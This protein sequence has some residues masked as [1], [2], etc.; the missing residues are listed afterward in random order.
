MAKM[1][2]YPIEK[3][4]DPTEER[5]YHLL[6][7]ELNEE[8]T[9]L[10]S[11]TWSQVSNGNNPDP[12][13]DF[14]IMKPGS[15]IIVL[16]V[17]GGRWERKR[18][19]WHC[20][21]EP[22]AIEDDPFAQAKSNR[23]A[24]TDLL[25]K[26]GKWS[27]QWFPISY[28]LAFPDTKFSDQFD[29]T[30]LPPILTND[31]LDYVNDWVARAMQECLQ[32]NYPSVLS[33]EMFDYT[34]RTLMKD[35]VMSLHDIFDITERELITLTNQQLELDQKLQ[36]MKKLTIQGCAGSGKTLMALRQARRLAQTPSVRNILFTCFNMELGNWL[37]NQT[38]SIRQRCTTKPFLMFCE[39][40]LREHGILTGKEVKDNEYYDELP[41]LMLEI[42]DTHHIK[43]NAI[44]VDEGQSFNT[45]WWVV[46]DQMLAD[47]EKSYRYIFYDELQR[48]YD[49]SD[50][51]VPGED[52]AINLDV[53]IRN[54]A[55]IHRKAIKFLPKDS[56]LP[57]CNS[58]KGEIPWFSVYEDEGTM[59][60]Y[61]QK[62][63]IALIRDGRVSA[64][65][66]VVLRGKKK[67]S[68][69]IDGEKLGSFI[70]TALE[71]EENPAAV[72]FTTIQSF[73][74]MERRVVILTEF[75]DEVKNIEQLNY[76]GA[77]RAK[78]MLAYLVSDKVAP[79][80]LTSLQEGCQLRN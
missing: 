9:V 69:F 40:L 41:L 2:P 52:E 49:E 20:Y 64:K 80:L 56:P 55:N 46:I 7:Q 38:H 77:S 34:V 47:K 75:D 37:Y 65:D 22:V 43:F 31:E 33:Y 44:I 6:E 12:E 53:N 63:L 15:G 60:Y 74:G 29:T 3:F 11:R 54:T 14:I 73:R 68:R 8:Y 21:G 45:D 10:Y 70:L 36:R 39:D 13:C 76:L 78:T 57:K 79:E 1:L 42:I 61:L 30:G 17:K 32:Q 67:K 25:K 35:Y 59:K 19:L 4:R 28:A 18:G 5:M 58:V 24:L 50:N 23:S 62:M 72:R 71:N 48:I 26:P 27:H 66:I 51:K 16:E